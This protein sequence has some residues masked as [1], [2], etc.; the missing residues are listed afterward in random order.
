M[1][2]IPK[3][4]RR[5]VG[6]LLLSVL[7][8]LA[9]NL[10]LFACITLPEMPGRQPWQTASETAQG[11][12]KNSRGYFLPK[13]LEDELESQH[14][15]AI[16]IDNQTLQAVWQ[17]SNVPACVPSSYTAS[18]ISELT[19]GYICDYPVFTGAGPDGLAVLGYPKK[20]FWKHLWPA[21]SYRLIA[22]F[23]KTAMLVLA[24]NAALIFLIYVTANSR[25]LSSV[26][27]VTDGIHALSSGKPVHVQEKGL[28]CELAANI[29]QTSEI[30]QAQHFQLRKK[31]TA[32]ANWIAGVSHDIRTPLSMVMGYAQQLKDEPGL[33]VENRR[34]ASVIAAQ[35][36]KIRSLVSDLNLASK[37]E[38]NMQPVHFNRENLTALVRQ[39]AADFI[40]MDIDG[41]HPIVWE[42]EESL[43]ACFVKA[44]KGLLKR[45]VSNLIQNS[46]THNETGCTI[47]IRV[48]VTG[49]DCCVE[50][51]DNG[52]GLTDT[53]IEKLNRIPHY[54]VCDEH[55]SGQR[56]GLGLLLVRQIAQS[57]GGTF[58]IGKSRDGGFSAT[59]HLPQILSDK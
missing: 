33:S 50:I 21:W 35:S 6:L 49:Q 51:S 7:A 19:R 13:Q 27:P 58:V 44:D 47:F 23:P 18:D 59:L 38:Y 40:N 28:L 25:L 43:P 1:K 8:L 9:C 41:T 4:I 2:S 54:M 57:H 22:G 32:R 53:Q 17:T 45:A 42:T 55:I 30:L 16:L 10:V 34:K 29:N 12:Q 46:I 56:H 15:W 31:E 37:L 5:S 11:I 36:T 24:V 48:F 14:I 26:R 52:T 3:L 39:A 20:S